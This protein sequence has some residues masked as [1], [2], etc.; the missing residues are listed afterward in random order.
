MKNIAILVFSLL[1]LK[2][3]F[4]DT[5]FKFDTSRTICVGDNVYRENIF[6]RPSLAVVVD[7]DKDGLISVKFNPHERARSFDY[8]T[9]FLSKGCVEG[10]CVNDTIV[11]G[12]IE[13]W[14]LKVI[15]ISFTG[16]ILVQ[17]FI[18]GSLEVISH[19]R[20]LEVIHHSKT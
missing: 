8:K 18:T 11:S 4:A 12:I 16:K 19:K 10:V 20:N 7:M 14:P 3:A 9:F 2:T 13:R 1:F 17:N 15:A 5:C 6:I